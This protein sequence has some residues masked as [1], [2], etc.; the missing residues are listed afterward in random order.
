MK[1]IDRSNSKRAVVFLNLAY[2]FYNAGGRQ[3]ML[4]DAVAFSKIAETILK[5]KLLPGD[6]VL[7]I[8]RLKSGGTR[9]GLRK[10]SVE[11]LA[12]TVELLER[13]KKS[14]D[15]PGIGTPIGI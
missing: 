2:H 9:E 6:I 5:Q 14:V 8:G 10:P 7:I 15:G 1:V 4:F 3:Q 11:V 13:G 12:N